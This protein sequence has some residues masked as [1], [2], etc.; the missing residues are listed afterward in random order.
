[1]V[2]WLQ[3]VWHSTYLLLPSFLL[4]GREDLGSG[5][6]EGFRVPP[7]WFAIRANYSLGRILLGPFR[8]VS[9]SPPSPP[10]PPTSISYFYL[11]LF[12]H[13]LHHHL[14]I[15]FLFLGPFRIVSLQLFLLLRFLYSYL[16]FSSSF[17][18]PLLH[19]FWLKILR[20]MKRMYVML[21]FEIYQAINVRNFLNGTRYRS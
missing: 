15:L 10:S 19:D 1:M 21:E 20:K 2:I 4:R 5:T 3:F 17:F 9:T 16:S 12:A 7:A 8:P 13:S 18:L 11:V 14:L 6:T